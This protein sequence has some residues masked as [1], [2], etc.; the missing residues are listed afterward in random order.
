MYI[1]IITPVYPS[2]FYPKGPTPVV[3]YFTKE[4]VAAGNRVTVY[5]LC[6]RFPSF[7]YIFGKVLKRSLTSLAGHFIPNQIPNEY[8]EVLD[9]VTVHHINI[10]KVIPYSRFKKKVINEAVRRITEI[11]EQD[12]PDLFIAHWDNPCLEMLFHLKRIYRVPTFLV[13]HG[14]IKHLKA[15][16]NKDFFCLFNDLTGIGFRNNHEK[17]VFEELYGKVTDSFDA[18]SGVSELFFSAPLK[19][20]DFNVSNSIVFIG[21]LIK[22]KYPITIVPAAS[23]AYGNDPF[24]IVYI[25]EGKEKERIERKYGHT[26]MDSITFTGRIPRESIISYLDNADVFI[27]ISKDEV[28]G[29]VYLEAMSRGCI[30]IA[31]KNESMD[32]IIRD[33]ENGFL[34]RA[35]DEDELARILTKI[36]ELSIDQKEMLSKNA[37]R[38]ARDLTDDK[39]AADYLLGVE[40]IIYQKYGKVLY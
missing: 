5:H 12:I 34:C 18:F 28:F 22:R 16:Y 8:T 13:L 29:L 14:G 24:H 1:S 30:T 3:H 7:F 37:I 35:G 40:R 38:T 4:W 20:R 33:G 10:R 39:A 23:R 36:Q 26:F 6:T 32:G 9:G 21:S 27:M 17:Q 19:E 11:V 25:G 15:R 31:S 2:K